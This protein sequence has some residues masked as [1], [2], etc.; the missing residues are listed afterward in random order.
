[1]SQ[2]AIIRQYRVVA[3]LRDLGMNSGKRNIFKTSDFIYGPTNYMNK[4][5]M[6]DTAIFSH[7]KDHQIQDNFDYVKTIVFDKCN[8]EFMAKNYNPVVFPNI[9]HILLANHLNQSSD[10]YN[11]VENVNVFIELPIFFHIAKETHPNGKLP[12]FNNIHYVS[13]ADIDDFNTYH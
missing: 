10:I 11:F 3:Y 13:R 12:Y 1:M 7:C 9:K 8:K 5:Y 2:L 4:I 6:G